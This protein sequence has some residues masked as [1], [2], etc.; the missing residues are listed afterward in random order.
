[1]ELILGIILGMIAVG[2]LV[3]SILG[4]RHLLKSKISSREVLKKWQFWVGVVVLLACIGAIIPQS[5][6]RQEVIGSVLHIYRE[7]N[8]NNRTWYQHEAADELKAA[9]IPNGVAEVCVWYKS[10]FTDVKGNV[11]EDT[12]Y[13]ISVSAQDIE[14]INWNNFLPEN[15][16]SLPSATVYAWEGLE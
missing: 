16:E 3:F 4:I 13:R 2:I 7:G 14:E 11:S 8:H 6:S 5:N 9:N 1:M 12:V 10:E 15:I